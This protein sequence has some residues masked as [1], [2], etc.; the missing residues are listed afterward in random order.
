MS[1]GHGELG[2]WPFWAPSREAAV[3]EALD[4]AG[5]AAGDRFVDL[6]CGDGQVLVA[7]AARG[8]SVVGVEGDADLADEAAGHL[9]DAGIDGEVF[10]GDLLDPHGLPDADVY[11]TY[12]A[13]ATL[14]RLTPLLAPRRGARLVTVDFPVPGLVATKRSGSAHL[15]RLPGRRRPVTAP[16]WPTAGTLVSTV[17]D[18]Q[19]LTCLELVHPAGPTRVRLAPSLAEVA[20]AVPGADRLPATGHLAVDL[21]WE[22]MPQG[23]VVAG[24]VRTAGAGSHAVFVVATDEEDEGMWDLDERQVRALRGALRRRQPPSTVADL[25]DATAG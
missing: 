20:A 6:G 21:R 24:T 8:A 18:C 17:A 19:S 22:P 3:T 4:L 7:A 1:G 12:L 11:F 16:G 25:V 9:V 23:A 10:V 13:P 2:T 14:Q 5:V 15:Y